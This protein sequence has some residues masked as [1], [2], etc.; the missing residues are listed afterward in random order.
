M[1]KVLHASK[2]GWF[3][4]CLYDF[5]PGD[6]IKRYNAVSLE[7]AMKNYWVLRQ[8]TISGSYLAGE[9]P[10]TIQS[11]SMTLKSGAEKEGDL[12]CN[13]SWQ[14]A[15]AYN[16]TDI[17][18]SWWDTSVNSIFKYGKLIV[19]DYAIGANFVNSQ[20]GGFI[21]QTID[22]S[23]YPES[24]PFEGMTLFGVSGNASN[25]SITPT[26]YWSYDGTWNPQTGQRL[27]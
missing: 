22:A 14:V 27:T 1:G 9:Y 5:I 8:F 17:N 7:T 26:A 19:P 21:L 24:F 3:P 23:D 2:S 13:P 10:Y 16:L 11:F 20:G 15:N 4:F 6:I 12:V 25:F 18:G